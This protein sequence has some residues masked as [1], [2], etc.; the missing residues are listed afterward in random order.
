VSNSTS[1]DRQRLLVG[2]R[3]DDVRRWFLGGEKGGQ[4]LGR[5]AQC[6]HYVYV[7]RSGIDCYMGRDPTVVCMFCQDHFKFVERVHQQGIVVQV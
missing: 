7:D 1:P 3:D 5:C 6:R 2:Y 4:K